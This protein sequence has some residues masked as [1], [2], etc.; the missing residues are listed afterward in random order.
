MVLVALMFSGCSFFA[1]RPPLPRQASIERLPPPAGETDFSAQVENADI[2]YFPTERAAS[3]GR[4]EPAMV[5]LETLEKRA[6]PFSIGWEMIDSSQQ[7]LLDRLVAGKEKREELIAQLD[8]AAN[9]R[10][11]E[12]C[13][14]VLREAR[15]TSVRY[16]A[17]G[18]PKEL[19]TKIASGDRLTT[20]EEN[21][22]PRGYKAAEASSSK[23]NLLQLEFAADGIVGSVRAAGSG[24]K[25]LVFASGPSLDT[26][27]GLPYFVAQKIK[28][29]QL[30]LG[31][32][33]SPKERSRVIAMGSSSVA[34]RR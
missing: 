30:V 11:R 7:P 14:A 1:R 27:T 10:A 4:S 18:C 22:L 16:V 23:G 28:V 2:I 29:R 13:R 9:G 25:L 12:H 31:P 17:L 20:E 26:E 3:G 19:V 5:L 6:Q 33:N 8:L 21:L 15:A 34:D 32:D 24:Q